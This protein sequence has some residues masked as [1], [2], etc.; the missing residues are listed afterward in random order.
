[1]DYLAAYSRLGGNLSPFQI[2]NT[3]RAPEMLFPFTSARHKLGGASHY[4]WEADLLKSSSTYDW[5]GYATGLSD[6]ALESRGIARGMPSLR[7]G[8]AERLIYTPGEGA[9]G[10]LYS[11]VAGKRHLLANDILLA[12]MQDESP[13][14]FDRILSGQR[15]AR[16]NPAAEAFLA[17]G[18]MHSKPGFKTKDVFTGTVQTSSGLKRGMADFLPVPGGFGKGAGYGDLVRGTTYPRGVLAFEALR[19]NKLVGGVVDQ[20]FGDTGGKFL[21]NVLGVSAEALP[22]TASTMFAR[23]GGRAAMVYAG[24]MGL[25]QLDWVRR[26]YSFPGHIFS[27][28]IVSAGISSAAWKMGLGSRSALIAGVGSFFGQMVLPGFE[29]GLMPGIATTYTKMNLLR[30]NAA[31][32][33]GYLRRTVEGFLPGFTDPETGVLLAVGGVALSGM[34]NPITGGRLQEAVW[35][36]L[37]PGAVSNLGI[38]SST[39]IGL[40]NRSTRDLFWDELGKL[41]PLTRNL[42]LSQAGVLERQ[43]AASLIKREVFGDDGLAYARAAN[44]AWSTAEDARRTMG[45]ANPLNQVLERR[46]QDIAGRYSGEGAGNWINRELRGFWA[47]AQMSFFGADPKA[48]RTAVKDFGFSNKMPV[49]SLGRWATL[50]LAVFGAHQLLTGGLLGSKESTNDLRKQ[51]SGEKLVPIRESRFWEAGGRPWRGGQIDFYRPHWYHMMMN[52]VRET[53]VWGP[54]EDSISPVGK[55]IRKNFSYYLE[56][57]N[58][59]NRP[60]P[61]SSAAFSDVPIIGGILGSTIGRLIK[62]PRLMH[63][64][65]WTRPGEG[66]SIEFAHARRG[67]VLD[68]AYGAGAPTPGRPRSPFSTTAQL[69]DISYQF[70]ELEGFT[71]FAKNLVQNMVTGEDIFGADVPRLANAGHMTD[72]RTRFWEMNLGGMG[73][74]NEFLRRI[75]PR[76]PSENKLYNPISNS[77]PSW[78]PDKFKIG[79]P[80]RGMDSGEARLPGPGFTALHP[81]LQGIDPEGYPLIYRYAILADVAPFSREYQSVKRLVYQRREKG[82]YGQREIEY[83]EQ[84]DQRHA[85]ATAG[86]DP[87]QVHENALTLPGSGLVRG[88]YGLTQ[89]MARKAAAP[90]EYMIPMGF[91]PMQKLMGGRGSIEQYEYERL[92]GSATAFWDKPWRDWFRPSMYSALNMMGYQGKPL[93][94]AEADHVGEYF[95]KLEFQKWM[96]LA[97]QAEAAGDTKARERYEWQAGQTRTG[98]NPAGSPMSIYWSLPRSERA[99]FNTF[100]FASDKE[101]SRIK[102]MV[103]AD[104]VHLYEAIWKRM[105]DGDPGMWAGSDSAVS[106]QYMAQQ[107]NGLGDYFSGKPMPRE[108]W[109]GWHS[110]VDM[111]DIK[112]RYIN[113]LG[114]DLHDYGLWESQLRKSMQQPMLEGSEDYLF[115]PGG[116]GLAAGMNARGELFRGLGTNQRPPY[117]EATSFPGMASRA[118]IIYHDDRH[119]DLLSK[120]AGYINAY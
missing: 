95:D 110:D 68:P 45:K 115:G 38:P 56:E 114:R 48:I 120:V 42:D 24:A 108:D 74:M 97:Q 40:I 111:S 85:R 81:E 69:S 39:E 21:K 76:Y 28:S 107:Q 1:M 86:Y 82:G 117:V 105:D 89:R 77:M 49:G 109:I 58:Y 62:P 102:E 44:R 78:I 5:L 7:P 53:G 99:F 25:S 87:N 54:E 27:S 4:A 112:V 55:F 88:A 83:M 106:D 119:N 66:D 32:P 70:R 30:A 96:T 92:Y 80:Y 19:F 10:S 33:F 61:I 43:Q 15:P 34:R 3:F 9:R 59:Y 60:Y 94:R 41:S 104:Q 47:Q 79:D 12:T 51:Y 35:N 64:S 50:G 98:V 72:W 37:S 36:R 20:V 118:K 22:G 63:T 75:L 23:Y 6:E 8:L 46:L 73:F 67:S 71:G 18:D 93:W 91:R 11:E 16:M 26:N 57:K 100:A 31:N 2:L 29:E 103:P 101:R 113:S 52:R 17:A 84:I 90:A 65:D 116:F 13:D 14:A